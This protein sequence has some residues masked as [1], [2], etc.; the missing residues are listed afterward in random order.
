MKKFLFLL[1]LLPLFNYT[2]AKK[3]KYIDRTTINYAGTEL[4]HTEGS[5]SCKFLTVMVIPFDGLTDD[6]H[7]RVTFT[8]VGKG[9]EEMMAMSVDCAGDNVSE[10]K[11]NLRWFRNKKK[12]SNEIDRNE[13]DTVLMSFW[14][15]SIPYEEWMSDAKVRIESFYFVGRRK[16]YIES[17]TNNLVIISRSEDSVWNELTTSQEKF[18]I[19]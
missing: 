15:K 4:I 11:R 8:M 14:T 18:I 9:G 2:Q 19:D 5:D 6:D 3:I 16:K 13:G 10:M 12:Y 17:V 1:I 7:M